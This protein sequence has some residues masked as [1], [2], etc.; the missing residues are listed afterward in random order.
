MIIELLKTA[1]EGEHDL[2]HF[3]TIQDDDDFIDTY[4]ESA[5][6]AGEP[7]WIEELCH[8]NNVRTWNDGVW[9]YACGT[10]NSGDIEV[11]RGTYANFTEE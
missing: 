11:Y 7:C 2:N 6:Y 9:V 4:R 5:A 10:A 3:Q 1:Y 8:L